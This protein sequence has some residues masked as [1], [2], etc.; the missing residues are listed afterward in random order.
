[1][2]KSKEIGLLGPR[3]DHTVH[4]DAI[5]SRNSK[6]KSSSRREADFLNCIYAK[7]RKKKDEMKEPVCRLLSFLLSLFFGNGMKELQI[8]LFIL[9][10]IY[11]SFPPLYQTFACLLAC[12]ISTPAQYYASA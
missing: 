8:S 6:R 3:D 12:I 9:I 1:M 2:R 4:R 10:F 7:E 11:W 5:K